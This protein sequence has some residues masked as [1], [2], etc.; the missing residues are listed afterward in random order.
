MIKYY[1]YILIIGLCLAVDKQFN[2]S[3][4]YSY[5]LEQCEFGARYPGSEGHQ[6]CKDFLFN[7]LSKYCDETIL[8]MHIIKDP[9]ALNNS[10]S[11]MLDS[12]K[13]YNIFGR[14]NPDKDKRILLIA[15][16]D[17]RR[18]AD[19]DP[20]IK[21][22]K[23]PV[24]GA[25]DGASG[26]A[27]ILTL[28][29]HFNKNNINN[30]GI[31]VLFADAEDMGLYGDADTWAIGS[32]L[33]SRNYPNP[34]P[35]FAICVDMVADKDLEIKMERYS[36]QMAPNLMNHIW[37][38]SYMMGYDAFKWEL[39]PAIIDDHLSFSTETKIPS[40]NLIDLDYDHWHTTHDTPYN[41]SQYSLEIVG[42]VLMSFLY[43]LNNSE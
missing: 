14:I 42:N 8:D 25:N 40:I 35:E 2:S 11:N 39:G 28:L 30:I 32:K 4:A 18:F 13:V 34:L 20:N 16:W 33:F 36:Y 27:V 31:D 12:V 3:R 10:N 9:L 41:I 15:H 23:E 22:H 24:L 38:L 21:N 5:V 1:I 17:T 37:N 6:K 29:N 43:N 7:E 26:V 19:K